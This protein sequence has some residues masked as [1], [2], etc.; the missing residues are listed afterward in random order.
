MSDKAGT[1]RFISSG[2]RNCV[3]QALVRGV[4]VLYERFNVS[5]KAGTT[6][7]ISSGEISCVVQAL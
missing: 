2:E 3:V 1:T 7:F 4:V 5:D 6:R